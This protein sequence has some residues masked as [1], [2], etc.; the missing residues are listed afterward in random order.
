MDEGGQCFCLVVTLCN[1]F[2]ASRKTLGKVRERQFGES[3]WHNAILR[4]NF[5]TT[6]RRL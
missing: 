5:K 3:E 4:K 6:E 1:S 2:S